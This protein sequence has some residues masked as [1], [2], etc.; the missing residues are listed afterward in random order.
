M[1]L[2]EVIAIVL[3]S[4]MTSMA[5]SVAGKINLFSISPVAERTRLSNRKQPDMLKCT[6][7]E[8]KTFDTFSHLDI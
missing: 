3:F 7:K 5:M 1:S 4:A 6:V 8:I 2:Y